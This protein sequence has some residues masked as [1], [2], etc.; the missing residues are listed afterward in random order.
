[1]NSME[2]RS[3]FFKFFEKRGHTK[4]ASSSLIPAQDPTLLFTNAGMNQFKDVF[5]GQEK[6]SYTRAVSIQ[7]C[8]RAGGKHNDLDNVGMTNRHLT[9]FEMMGNFSFGDYFKKDAIT[10]AW[11]CL[12]KDFGLDPKNMYVT[13][14]QED[15][16]SYNIWHKEV[17]LPQEKISKLGHKDNFWQ[18]GD[19]GP[20]GPCTEIY[21]DRGPSIGCG[22][23]NCAPGCS[24]DR[25]LE[26]W[27]LVFMQFNRQ[28]DGTD[29]PLKQTG[30]DTGMGLERLALVLEK[31]ESVFETDLFAPIIQTT[32]TLTGLAYYDS[33]QPLKNAFNV[34]A[35][36]V[37]AATFLI[38]DGATPSNEGRGYVLRKVIRRGALFAQK[39]TDKNIFPDLAQ[40]VIDFMSPIYPELKTAEKIIKHVLK[41]EIDKFAANLVHGQA[42]LEKF[43]K[44]SKGT[45][46]SG[47]QAFKLYDTYGFPLELT[48]VIAHEKGYTVDVQEF[49]KEMELQRERSGAK[50]EKDAIEKIELPEDL[51]TTFVGYEVTENK[52]PI[53]TLI[54][55]NTLTKTIKAGTD[56]WVIT[57][58]TPF[59]VEKG[60]QVSDEG[61]LTIDNHTAPIK[62]LKRIGNCIA[63]HITAPIALKIGATVHAHVSHQRR[64]D[65]MNNHTATHLL[66]SALIQVLGKEV[67]QSGSLVHPDYLRFDFTYH[68]AMTPEEITKVEN[69][70]N[71]KIRENLPVSIYETTYDKAIQKGVIAI[72]GEKYNPENVRVIDIA[73]FSMELCGGTHVRRTGD[74][75]LLK[76]TEEGALSAGQRRIVALT[77]RGAMEL[78][79]EDFALTKKL[80]QEYKVPLAELSHAVEK[81][82]EQIKQLQTQI[83]HLKKDAWKAQLPALLAQIEQVSKIPFGFFNLEDYTVD[84][85][86]MA[87]SDLM[88]QKSGFYFLLGGNKERCAFFAMAP[89]TLPQVD[90]QKFAQ[91]LQTTFDLRGGGKKGTLQGGGAMPD[92]AQLQ[93]KIKDWLTNV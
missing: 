87:A 58:E 13:V 2:M 18:M 47:E 9:F 90:L 79:Q 53:I 59:F 15:N 23:K 72:F 68:K 37:R 25:F 36:H 19:T 12:T 75:G 20:C 22:Q 91:F 57:K 65:T 88:H 3:I 41:T 39:L 67:R 38:A 21:V 24:C 6:R 33:T 29:L 77:G 55:N 11:E 83:K 74:I 80:C 7:K 44:E 1:M 26:V 84:E 50:L 51:A 45:V 64:L 42:I 8:M 34:I 70:V 73:P 5:L 61:T 92:I 16:E 32:E 49:D 60:G 14:F 89:E 86:R 69:L 78:F 63:V 48:R 27:N 17:G 76:I 28:E 43:F 62:D 81:Q 52:S 66:Q 31:K 54:E 71:Q 4:I 40:A 82:R 46:I 85:L 93:K 30:V 35:D 56:C 10:W